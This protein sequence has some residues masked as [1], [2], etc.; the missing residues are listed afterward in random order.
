MTVLN[1]ESPRNSVD[2]VLSPLTFCER[3]LNRALTQDMSLIDK[4]WLSKVRPPSAEI[5]ETIR[6]CGY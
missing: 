5:I 4:T 3:R 6:L 1:M 2:H